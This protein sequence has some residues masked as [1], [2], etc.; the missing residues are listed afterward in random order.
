MKNTIDQVFKVRY[1]T[2]PPMSEDQ[3]IAST[4]TKPF[5]DPTTPV[6]PVADP[7]PV[8]TTSGETTTTTTAPAKTQAPAKPATTTTAKKPGVA[9]VK[10]KTA[11]KKRAA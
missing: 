1:G 8:K 4:V 9:G 6:Q 7:E 2:T 5:V 3:W 10:S 11:A